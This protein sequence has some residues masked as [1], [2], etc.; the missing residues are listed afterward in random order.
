ML[1]KDEGRFMRIKPDEIEP[2]RES[3]RFLR[4]HNTHIRSFWTSWE[5][6]QDLWHNIQVPAG[7]GTIKVRASR[8][9][10]RAA[11]EQTLGE[12][13]GDEEAALV[14]ID[15]REMPRV[16]AQVWAAENIGECVPRQEGNPVPG[17]PGQTPTARRP[18]RPERPP[19]RGRCRT[20]AT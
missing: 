17:P 3:L 9:K 2:L 6:F 13:L 4:E 19:R 7:G 12:T 14:I 15:P 8:R 1:G 18:R 10:G 20:P 11:V 5:R 16:W